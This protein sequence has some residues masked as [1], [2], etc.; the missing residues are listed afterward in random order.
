M[1][2]LRVFQEINNFNKFLFLFISTCN[3]S[4]A[5]FYSFLILL[6]GT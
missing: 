2:L 3:I 1:I 4:K 6:F 5:H